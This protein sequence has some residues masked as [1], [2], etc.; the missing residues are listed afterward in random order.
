MR[1]V[2]V[3]G[4]DECWPW[5]GT[6]Q[7][8]AQARGKPPY[9]VWKGFPGTRMVHRIAYMLHHGLSS[10]SKSIVVHHNCHKNPDHTPLCCNPKHLELMEEAAHRSM[11]ARERWD[12]HR[13][14]TK[15]FRKMRG[16]K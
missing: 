14:G 6:V 13:D 4:E 9:G 5:Q 11:H 12:A 15:P 7:S 1:L 8:P 16:M 3:R 10:L 2:D